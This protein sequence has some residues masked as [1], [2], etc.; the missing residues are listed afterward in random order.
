MVL[1]RGVGRSARRTQSACGEAVVA[2]YDGVDKAA[3]GQRRKPG[4]AV[5]K[6]GVGRGNKCALGRRAIMLDIADNGSCR[7]CRAIAFGCTVLRTPL[8]Y[9]GL[10]QGMEKRRR[11]G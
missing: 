4:G 2:E 9:R 1:L 3:G 6:C 10:S 5:R 7:R 8:A 11:R